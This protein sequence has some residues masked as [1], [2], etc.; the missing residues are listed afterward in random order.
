MRQS[1]LSSYFL[2]ILAGTIFACLAAI[3][4]HAET[5]DDKTIRELYAKLEADI[6]DKSKARQYM[7]DRLA[8]NYSLTLQQS[9]IVNGL[10]PQSSKSALNREET[11]ANALKG[12][13]S[14]SIETSKYDIFDIKYSQD[15]KTAYVRQ[16]VTMTG[17]M[18]VP[19]GIPSSKPV[20]HFKDEQKCQE[21]LT[22]AGDKIMFLQTACDS[23]LFVTQ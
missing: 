21:A 11:L 8:D 5:L 2:V 1:C 22:L 10:P 9:A 4:A 20:S 16:T 19:G 17:T 12:Y 18:M 7:Q 6:K 13:D 23:Q 3:P 14:M 15:R